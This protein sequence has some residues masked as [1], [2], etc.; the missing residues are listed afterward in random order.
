MSIENSFFKKLCS[1]NVIVGFLKGQPLL[2]STDNPN[3][4]ISSM[5]YDE[6]IGRCS[7]NPLSPQRIELI[8][9]NII[10]NN[11]FNEE[12]RF[13]EI[14]SLEGVQNTYQLVKQ[15][16]D[17]L[18][19]GNALDNT[20]VFIYTGDWTEEMIHLSKKINS[21]V[22][23]TLNIKVFSI[24]FTVK[25]HYPKFPENIYFTSNVLTSEWVIQGFRL[26]YENTIWSRESNP[27]FSWIAP[28]YG[29]KDEE[30]EG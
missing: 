17:E 2:L 15:R 22:Y 18:K 23:R 26:R 3:L 9:S 25:Q 21:L 24:D 12:I 14:N 10:E 30:E 13:S 16:K 6:N 5:S 11:R 20:L 29:E 1:E 7:Y 27:I 4:S 28:L 19:K 8:K